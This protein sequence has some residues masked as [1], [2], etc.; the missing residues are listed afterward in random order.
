MRWIR[1][2]IEEADVR[3][4]T[5]GQI[6]LMAFVWRD[7]RYVISGRLGPSRSRTPGLVFQRVATTDGLVFLLHAERGGRYI[8]DAVPDLLAPGDMK[9]EVRP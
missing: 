5:G 6:E 3:P 4:T 9:A 2:P 7:T 8:L 1:E